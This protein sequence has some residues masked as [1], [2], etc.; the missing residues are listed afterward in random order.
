[1]TAYIIRRILLMIPTLLGITLLVFFVMKAAPGDVADMLISSEGEMQAGDR[2]AR[3][4]YI[5]QRYGLDK[6]AIVQYGRWLNRVSPVGFRT[7]SQVEYEEAD[8]VAAR[9]RLIEKVPT[10]GDLSESR[11]EKAI[12]NTAAH[13]S[14][15]L[16]ET[17][18]RFI[19]ASA[20]A[21]ATLS[22]LVELG[23]LEPGDLE[24]TAEE[25]AARQKALEPDAEG[26]ADEPEAKAPHSQVQRQLTRWKF[27]VELRDLEQT[28][29]EQAQVK[30][31]THLAQEASSLDRVLFSQPIAKSPDFG[32]SFVKNRPVY[33]L[34]AD[35]LP[36]T[37]LLNVLALPIVYLL[38]IVSGVVAAR[39][40]GG[41]F[42]VI[43]GL[44]M[45]TLWSIPTIWAGVMLVGFLAN[46]Q[47]INI[48]PGSGLHSLNVNDMSFLPRWTD[49]GL[50]A[51]WL[52]DMAWHL[53]LPVVCIGYGAYAFMGKLARG[54]VLE[55]IT[56]DYVRTA[57][58]KG[59]SGSVVLWRHAFRN[60]LLPLI[61][62]GAFIIPGMIGG[63]VVVEF[64]FG[65]NG[66]GLLFIDSI[67]F[68]DQEV[69]MALTLIGGV[70]SLIAYLVADLLYAVADPRVAYD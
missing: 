11:V 48:F 8:V 12:R 37:I 17:V 4:E 27:V 6:P 40:R 24:V 20:D 43:S 52:L 9:D 19:E 65:I 62:V 23:D 46:E 54:A 2:Q 25:L 67:K 44:V 5:R 53:V 1:M 63:S 34:V 55:N 10:F 31:V 56:A 61:T 66:M 57:R 3:L 42:D 15:S 28:N 41:S 60:S 18:D 32:Q 51:G 69:V 22:Y 64:I 59:L 14:M 50:E 7:S 16:D 38:A 47:F 26:D 21:E 58:A 68:K 45:V 30:A 39:K 70:L 49:D 13:E 33:D 29:A 36:I 35:S